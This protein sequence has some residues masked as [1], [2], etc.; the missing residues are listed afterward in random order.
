LSDPE[1]LLAAA[2]DYRKRGWRVI[3]LHSVGPDGM[4]CSCRNGRK[5]TSKGKHPIDEGWQNTPPLGVDDIVALWE[6][7][8]KA[9]LGLAVGEA[10][11][12]WVLDIDPKNG[13]M[14]SMAALVAEH[15]KLPD[16]FVV[17]TGSGGY[18]YY[19]ALPDF[20]LRNSADRIGKGID[21]RANGGQVVAAPSK[22]DI[23]SYS[24]VQDAPIAPA[25]EWLAEAARKQ[26][27]DPSTIVTAAD[28]PRPEDIAPA[29]WDRLNAYTQRALELERERLRKLGIEGWAGAPWNHT[30]FEVACTLLEFANSPWNSYSVGQAQQDVLTLTPRDNDGFDD[31]TVRKTFESA[32]ERIGQKARAMPEAPAPR[33]PDPLFGGPDVRRS[34]PTG[35]DG[36][37][38][39]P[40]TG[41]PGPWDFFDKSE[42]LVDALADAIMAEGPIAW[43]R[44]EAFWS[45]QDGVWVSDPHV[46]EARC[47]RLLGSKYRNSHAQNASTVVRH[48]VIYLPGDP[49]S[50]WINFRNGMLDWRTG[51][52]MAHDPNLKSTVQMAVEYLPDATCPHFDAFLSDVMHDDY[53]ELA[54]EMLGYLMYS[55]NPMQVA[56]M[57]YGSGGNGK[58]TLMRVIEQMLGQRNIASESLDDLNSNRFSAVNLFGRIANLAGDIDGTYQESTA[59]FKKLTGEDTYAGERKFGQRFTF[60]SWA[61]PV[62][63]ANK[64]PGS[65][66]VTEGY[67]RRWI[68][69]HFHKHITNPITGLS[70]RL[71][72]ELPGIAYKATQA[73][74]VLMERGRFDPHGEAIKGKLEF[75]EAIDQVRQWIASGDAITSP[76]TW[77]PLTQL[78]SSYAIWAERSGQRKVREQEF[79]HRLEAI[80]I[81]KGRENGVISH[82]GL[83]VNVPG[84]LTVETMF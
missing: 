15:G 47:V 25:P 43:G 51:E 41:G 54:W 2:L 83:T 31:Y 5:C 64:I 7:R 27:V 22:S 12:F 50:R 66:D 60:Q 13:G 49:V 16:T 10:S 61:V 1:A 19:F 70:D 65:A 42:L 24:I 29:E 75:A 62:F 23:G 79:S 56:F 46:V 45:F 48:S 69:L 38:T 30:T 81:P 3:Q 11:G 40:V 39:S 35:G 55:G 4:T 67:L 36:E 14:D 57:F 58:G 76:G 28:L 80:G 21:T 32:R 63:S 17:Q 44:D 78:Y 53:V 73:L 20:E 68:I 59:N 34:N 84:R 26:D 18:H 77:T 6:K 72:E 71:A 9:N 33:E 82:Q 8:P 74:R 52:L 37:P